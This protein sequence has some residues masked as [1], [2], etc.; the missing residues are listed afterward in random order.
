MRRRLLPT[1]VAGLALLLAACS[2]PSSTPTEEVVVADRTHVVDDATTSALVAYE[3]DGT[4]RFDEETA[5]LASLVVGDVLV[6]G[7][8]AGTAQ[9]GFLR[10]VDAIENDGGDVLLR[11]S[12]AMLTE[13]F[14]RAEATFATELRPDMVTSSTRHL[15]G[16]SLATAG[17]AEFAPGRLGPQSEHHDFMVSFDEVLVEQD[18]VTVSVDGAFT[19]DSEITFN[20]DIDGTVLPPEVWVELFELYI[21][22]EEHAEINLT[23]E[24]ELTFEHEIPLVTFQIASIEFLVGPVPVV[25]SVDLTLFLGADGEIFARVTTGAT[26]DASLDAGGRYSRAG[27]WEGIWEPE[28]SFEFTPPTF[29]ATARARAFVGARLAAGL[30]GEN[31]AAGTITTRAFLEGEAN[32]PADPLWCIYAGLEATYGYQISLPVIGDLAEHEEPLAGLRDE[33]ACADNAPPEVSIVSPLDGETF[34]EAADWVYA[35]TASDREMEGEPTVSWT[36]DGEIA[37]PGVFDVRTLCPGD[38]TLVATARD[39]SG[40][41]SDDAVTITIVNRVPMVSIDGVSPSSIGEGNSV[42]FAGSVVDPTCDDPDGTA[43]DPDRLTWTVQDG[44]GGSG[45]TLL[46]SFG[47]QGSKEVELAYMDDGGATGS[48]SATVDV[49]AFDPDA[50]PVVA[51]VAPQDGRRYDVGEAQDGVYQIAVTGEASGSVADADMIWSYRNA[52]AGGAFTQFGTGP[53]ATLAFDAPP[54]LRTLEIRLHVD[55]E[56]IADPSAQTITVVVEPLPL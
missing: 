43:V 21:T 26:Q 45:A 32:V 14:V 10:K 54:G 29:E 50:P 31:G 40:A 37:T 16:L 56:P 20:L 18:G 53:D 46:T 6:A 2:G 9:S 51:I 33:L 49:G 22:L 27:G 44:F 30:Y 1:L 19:F 23:A 25:L 38:H 11:T 48:D 41:T 35:A 42:R 17:D 12:Q 34:D 47:S 39:A 7:P 3:T 8:I 36:I 13:T 24:A 4:L 52:D 15:E 5:L 55:G 28:S